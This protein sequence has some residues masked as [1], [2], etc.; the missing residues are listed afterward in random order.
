MRLP[1]GNTLATSINPA[2]GAVEFDRAGNEVW[3][4]RTNTRVTRA[5]RR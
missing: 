1:N 2:I 5:I 4:Y 3:H